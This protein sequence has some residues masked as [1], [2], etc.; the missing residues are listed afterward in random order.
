VND[1][2][3]GGFV[4]VLFLTMLAAVRLRPADQK[5]AGY[6]AAAVFATMMLSTLDLTVRY[7]THHLVN[8][9]AGPNS[10][11]DDVAAAEQL[12]RLGARSGDKVAVV[13]A[14][15]PGIYWARLAKLR[16]VAEVGRGTPTEDFWELSD[17]TRQRVYDA[18][19]GTNSRMVVARC[20]PKRVEGWQQVP[21]SSLCV[22]WLHEGR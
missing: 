14:G 12:S 21:G 10:T 13:S 9:G 15:G 16:I 3:L 7:A 20:P 19:A 1:R 2:Y 17:E 18:L 22:L 6:V 8:E 5:A 4:L 11:M